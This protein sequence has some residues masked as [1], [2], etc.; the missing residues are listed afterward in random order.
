[1]ANACYYAGGC[2]TRDPHHEKGKAEML[3]LDKSRLTNVFAT[4]L[5]FLLVAASGR[6]ADIN[7]TADD[8]FG[9]SSFNTAGNWS[10]AAP[11]SAGNDYFNNGF[12]LRTP[13][14]GNSYTFG[15]D[16]LTITS[17]GGPGSDL[18]DALMYKGTGNTGVITVNNLTINGGNLRQ[19]NSDADVFNLAG[20]TLTVGAAGMGVHLQGPLNL[21]SVLVG[22]G[23][24]TVLANGSNSAARVF[25]LQNSSNTFTGDVLLPNATQSRF[26]VDDGANFLFDIDASGVNNSISGAGIA[27][28]NGV[29]DFDLTGASST[30]GDSW[31][32]VSAGTATYG[33]T[34]G[35]TGF[36]QSGS[37]WS[38]GTYLF[39]TGTGVLSV[40]QAPVEWILDADGGLFSNGVNW[41][42][43]SAPTDG[44]NALFGTV[45]TANRTVVLDVNRTLNRLTFNNAGDG[46]YFITPQANQVLTLSGEAAV[47]VQSGRHW[48]RVGVAGT[49][50]LTKQGPGE[51]VLDA[52]NTFSGGG[53][54]TV[55]GGYVS[56][57]NS[58]AIP[59]GTNIT[60]NGTDL[61]LLIAGPAGFFGDNGASGYVGGTIDGII[62]GTG[63]I[64]VG[65]DAEVTFSGTNTHSGVVVVTGG[66]L[67]IANNSALG[68]ADGTPATQT[69]VTGGETD[70]KLSLSG[71]RS[72]ADEL[73]S[74][75][76]RQGAGFENV[77]VTSA[78]SNS[79]AGNIKGQLGG[80]QYNL[81][82][83]SGTL[84]LGGTLSAPDSNSR[85]FVFSGAGNFNL[86]GSITDFVT[87][88]NGDLLDD[89][90]IGGPDTN[91]TNNVNVFKRGTGTLTIST[92]SPNAYDYWQGSTVIESGV[93]AVQSVNSDQGE[94]AT[95]S[96]DVRSGATFNV[97][98]FSQ[99]TIQNDQ[100]LSG[101]GTVNTGA[102]N[103]RIF[104]GSNQHISP[105]DDGVG[106]LNVSGNV[107]LS[108]LGTGGTL[109]YDLGNATTVGGTENDLIA[110]SGSL[111]TPSGSPSATVRVK[112]VEGDLAASTY[113]LMTHNSGSAPSVGGISTVQVLD[114]NNNVLNTRHT[115]TVTSTNTQVNLNVANN[116]LALTWNGPGGT[117]AWDHTSSNWT[118]GATSFRDLDDVTF[119]SGGAKNVTVNEVVS[120]GTTTFN[121]GSTYT[122]TGTGGITGY[123]AVNVSSG[124]V[125]LRNTGNSFAGSTTVASGATLE[126]A[127]ASTGG[128]TING[129]L[130]LG[131]PASTTIIDDF[132][133]GLGSYANTVILDT[134]VNGGANTAIWQVASGAAQYDTTSFQSIEQ[135]A[136]IRSGLSLA[137]GEELQVDL[138]HTGAS[139][140]IGLYVGGTPVTAASGAD[141][142]TRED[143]ISVYGRGAGEVF[144]RGFNGAAELGLTGG[145]A[146]GYTSLFIARTGE[147]T[148]EAGYYNASGRNVITTRTP[149]TPND[150]DVV[151]FYTDVRALGTLGDLDNL[152]VVELGGTAVLDVNGDF[153]L[154]STGTLQLDI[155]G[156]GFDS[157]DISGAATLTGAIAVNLEAGITPADGAQYT[158][159]SADGGISTALGS[160]NFGAGLPDGFTASYNDAMTDLILTFSAGLDGDFN[161][162]GVVNIADYTVWRDNLG[163]TE[164]DLLNGNGDG[165][166]VTSAD[167]DLWKDNFGAGLSAASQNG[168]LAAV[169]EPASLSLLLIGAVGALFARRRCK[170]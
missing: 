102:G 84:T 65:R 37:F 83:T 120:P 142:D 123:G 3:I 152:R 86:T 93:L 105:G 19:A 60:L 2:T 106:T 17:P 7:L 155:T 42:G 107:V 50:G 117:A 153:L 114:N 113:R 43:G 38:D 77:H 149:S 101:A 25:H 28:F 72:I 115:F 63:L 32:L 29:F 6:A 89:D 66:T 99:Y 124:T 164:G 59:S 81:E 156:A 9:A 158:V 78:G 144:S 146:A 148:F 109:D 145:G 36:T 138:A 54:L 57:T 82:S 33:E 26:A 143:F 134:D 110:I 127:S 41:S 44:Q 103:V 139:Q 35:I 58:G 159:L 4:L 34:F 166:T 48:L 24:I 161:G 67:T 46:D 10:N 111:T 104:A 52:S 135:T 97:S 39:N 14:D 74:L 64:E 162:D 112:P 141:N 73:L 1:M 51:L 169:P 125:R 23:D 140:D 31:N 119:G 151:G 100:S 116:D 16:S 71:G 49:Q 20:N 129:T 85:N 136:F 126:M 130:G 45:I 90:M 61:D 168:S 79:W 22:T 68:Q 154:G 108:N 167:Y 88:A 98:S 21:Q 11:P 47:D 170:N 12:L 27:T 94:L 132:S 118:G 131:M 92:A 147:N 69:V 165:G 137:V 8:G 70:G 80:T 13:A 40:A 18:N 5:A 62:S 87:D 75:D 150:A 95:S 53:G 91:A 160:L 121:S 55:D 76:A 122:F 96:I 157:L 30:S 133:G 56:I 128:M 163:A 15:G